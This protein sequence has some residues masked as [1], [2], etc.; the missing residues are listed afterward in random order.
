MT[1]RHQPGDPECGAS[2]HAL[3]TSA[4]PDVENY[5][6]LDAVPVKSHLVCKVQYPSCA[7]CAYEG[8]KILVYENT[9]PVDAMRWR[10]IDPHFADPS[11]RTPKEAPSP[12]ARFPASDDGW[13]RA[14]IFAREIL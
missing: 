6:I 3:R 8:V 10:R 7:K 5:D 14:I 12:A 9:T 2:Y 4:T 11:L 1:C 13:K